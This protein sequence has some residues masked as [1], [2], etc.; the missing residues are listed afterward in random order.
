VHRLPRRGFR[1]WV[2]LQALPR[3]PASVGRLG[4][5][6]HSRGEE[7]RPRLGQMSKTTIRSAAAPMASATGR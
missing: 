3:A 1:K 4:S 2:G 6:V 7:M 5:L